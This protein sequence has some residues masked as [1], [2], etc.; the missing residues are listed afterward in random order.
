M[1]HVSYFK[2]D[3]SVIKIISF[4]IFFMKLQLFSQVSLI[5]I[6]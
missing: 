3:F 4:A 6:W 1:M 5:V 2:V